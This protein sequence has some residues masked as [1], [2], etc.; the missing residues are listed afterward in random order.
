MDS[1][2]KYSDVSQLFK[3]GLEA[4]SS[5]NLNAARSIYEEILILEPQHPEANHNLGALYVAQ[6]EC[7]KALELF[8][9]ALAYSPNVSLFWA[10]YI[11][12]LIKLN[13]I[14]DAKTI[15]QA[16]KKSGLFCERV[17]SLYQFLEK[18]YQEPTHEE[19]VE[20]DELQFKGNYKEVIKRCLGLIKPYPNSEVICLA[21]GDAYRDLGKIDQAI[22][23]YKKIADHQAQSKQGFVRLGEL[24]TKIK[25]IDAAIDNFQRALKIDPQDSAICHLLGQSFKDQDDNDQARKYFK[26]AIKINPGNALHHNAL[27]LLLEEQEDHKSAARSFRKA[28]KI[29]PN[30]ARMHANLGIALKIIDRKNSV[31]S[32][33]KCIEIDPN[34]PD[35]LSSLGCVLNEMGRYTDAKIKIQMALKLDPLCADA[36]H[37]LAV[38]YSHLGDSLAAISS[39]KKA[40]K[41]ASPE[42]ASKSETMLGMELLRTL[43]FKNGWPALESRWNAEQDSTFINTSKPQWGPTRKDD[44]VFLW[45]EQ[46]LGDLV[47]YSSLIEELRNSVGQLIFQVDQRLI[48]LFQRSFSE[49][50]RFIAPQRKIF[51]LEYDSHIPIG[52]LPLHFR[53][54]LKSFE[55]TSGRY[56][57]HNAELTKKI[58]NKLQKD[59]KREIYGISWRG[60]SLKHTVN[61]NKSIELESLVKIFN[62]EKV[63]L[64]SLQYGDTSQELTTLAKNHGINVISVN[65][66]CNLQDIDGLASLICACDQVVSMDNTT[67]FLAGALGRPTNVLVPFTSDWRWG[68]NLRQSYWHSSLRQYKQKKVHDWSY[69]LKHLK[70]DL[71]KI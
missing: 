59:D 14:T 70:M 29:L 71:D 37:N 27:G 22:T 1:N 60:G 13:R 16:A 9:T 56:L 69:P 41:N 33:E 12:T 18:K 7:L 15:T 8:K 17:Q 62:H 32:F 45:E 28:I 47:M 5:N 52:S 31:K 23:S 10:S 25:N 42:N 43:N 54:S 66:I 49:D 50:I 68:P 35:V 63:Q 53:P 11:N 38:N 46:G 39:L 26:K 64:V 55:K 20:L 61:K 36:H 44:R 24:N 3:N 58:K 4:Q 6:D 34:R 48:P 2:L 40:V 30:D 51:E 21:L 65:E 19:A 57:Q 67:V